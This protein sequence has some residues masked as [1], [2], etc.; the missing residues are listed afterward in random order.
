[1]QGNPLQFLRAE[2]IPHYTGSITR[3]F[4][5]YFGLQYLDGGRMNLSCNNKSLTLQGTYA[6][7]VFP[8][9]LFEYSPAQPEG[10]WS[11]HYVTFKGMRTEYYLAENLLPFEPQIILPGLRMAE[12]MEQL[13]KLINR[14]DRQGQW[15][16]TNI[17]E[18][19]LLDLAEARNTHVDYPFWL[20]EMLQ[21]LDKLLTKSIDYKQ[22]S[23]QFNMTEHNLRRSFKTQS[24]V[25]I[26]TY[27]LL[28]KM[29]LACDLLRNST[30]SIKEIANQL[31]YNDIYFFHRQFK[32]YQGIPPRQYRNRKT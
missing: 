21:M 13:R 3:I 31:G 5:D 24:G 30:M 23:E 4:P 16:A 29:S 22:L 14:P 15:T 17:L 2:F 7:C 20:P 18:G 32:Q 12:R 19:L 1:M 28:K 11:H 10:Y 27:V 8:G 6:W 26:H 9:P 25:P